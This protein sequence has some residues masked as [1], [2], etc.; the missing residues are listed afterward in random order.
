MDA[1]DTQRLNDIGTHWTQV[2]LALSGSGPE[3]ARAQ[4]ELYQRYGGAIRRYLQA[5]LNDAAVVDDLTQEFAVALVGGGFDNVRPER[6]RFRDYIKGV[7]FRLVQKHRRQ[8]YRHAKRLAAVALADAEHFPDA[9]DAQFRQSWR[10]ELLARTWE[11]LAEQ[12]PDQHAVL[13]FR[14]AHPEMRSEKLAAEL[15]PQLG[16]ALTA[17]GVRQT[18]RR[19]RKQFVQCLMQLVAGSLEFPTPGAIQEELQDLE[20]AKFVLAT[21]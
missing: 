21:P 20:L 16:K 15:G 4:G 9:C 5:A 13:H 2:R 18:L 7:L 19:A 14:A 8:E 3:K 11:K 10:D 6:G 17:Q 12:D 1:Y